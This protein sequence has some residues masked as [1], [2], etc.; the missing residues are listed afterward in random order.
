[1]D[2]DQLKIENKQFNEKCAEKNQELL[3]LKL[4]A[5]KTLQVLNTHKVTQC[6]L[7]YLLLT[8]LDLSSIAERVTDT[9]SGVF[10]FGG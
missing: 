5:G 1:M 10:C 6:Q 8:Q 3:N 2:Y 4:K 9:L 7:R